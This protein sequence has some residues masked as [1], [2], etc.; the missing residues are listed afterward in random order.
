MGINIIIFNLFI[1]S[2]YTFLY[3]Y[4]K[5]LKINYS[6]LYILFLVIC[7]FAYLFD[8]IVNNESKLFFAN[9]NDIFADAYKMAFSFDFF[10]DSAILQ[11]GIPE[12]WI[13]NNPYNSFLYE[14]SDALLKAG[15]PGIVFFGF[16]MGLIL[17]ILNFNLQFFHLLISF[18]LLCLLV[19]TFSKNKIDLVYL[20]VFLASYPTVFMYERGNLLSVVV[21]FT[22]FN[23]SHKYLNGQSLNKFDIFKLAIATSL[24]PT[25]G[26]FLLLFFNKNLFN[27]FKK[28]IN[29]FFYIA[30]LNLTLFY[31]LKNEIS[32]YTLESILENLN[33]YSLQNSFALNYWDSSLYKYLLIFFKDFGNYLSLQYVILILVIIISV[34]IYF[35]INRT[36]KIVLI[37]LITLI[38]LISANPLGPYHLMILCLLIALN[39]KFIQ[40][41]KNLNVN[42]FYLLIV[43]PKYGNFDFFNLNLELLNVI[44]SS[45]FVFLIA[46]F[47]KNLA[48][49]KY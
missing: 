49:K 38:Y 37:N 1:F 26:I 23:L 46:I 17:N 27:D 13:L 28:A 12:S 15:L 2:F 35:R 11:Y 41:S 10:T 9:F 43:F 5:K 31:I 45:V 3:K 44:N 22:L 18:I 30:T 19:R 25:A 32:N 36:D 7:L 29:F 14:N 24:R 20:L 6:Y 21:A 40:K 47:L 34:L 8:L 4:S 16:L 48:I 39:S 33:F 42:I